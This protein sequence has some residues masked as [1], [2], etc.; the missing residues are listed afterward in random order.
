MRHRQLRGQRPGEAEKMVK[1]LRNQGGFTLVE[2]IVV[3]AILAILASLLVPSLTG[4]IDRAKEE[5]IKSETRMVLM[6]LQTEASS[7][8]AQDGF[9]LTTSWSSDGTGSDHIQNVRELAELSDADRHFTAV[10]S[11]DGAVQ[12]LV[13]YSDGKACTY[14]AD[15]GSYTVADA[16]TAI[17]SD[18]VTFQ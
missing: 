10:L 15:D 11:L 1:K 7:V 4:Y 5:K 3:M 12:Q 9:S 16:V 18:T 8:Y 6:A 14:L 13:Y 2:L 17:G